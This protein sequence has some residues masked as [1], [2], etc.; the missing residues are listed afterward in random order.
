[1][2]FLSESA[3]DDDVS[4]TA[5]GDWY[6]NRIVVDRQPL[7]LMVSSRSLLP[8]LAP[9]REVRALPQRL[10]GMVADRLRRL[11]IEAGLIDAELEA[12]GTVR[13]GRTRDR[14]VVGTLIDFE[15]ALPY[16]LPVN[17]WDA[18][19]LRFAEKRLAGTPCRASRPFREVIFPD[20]AAPKLL[21]ERWHLN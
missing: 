15:K 5:L 14:S 19:T 17:G 2:R 10:P 1:L 8:L 18:F 6:V 16:D 20:Q 21:Q 11:G 7:L 9:A 3:A 13:V 12:M 4:D